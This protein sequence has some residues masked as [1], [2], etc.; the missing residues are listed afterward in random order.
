[1]RAGRG[2]GARP[3]V[4]GGRRGHPCRP[5]ESPRALEALGEARLPAAERRH[6]HAAARVRTG[7]CVVACCGAGLCRLSKLR[8]RFCTHTAHD[9]APV[10][11]DSLGGV[12]SAIVRGGGVAPALRPGRTDDIRD[13]AAV[14]GLLGRAGGSE[15]PFRAPGGCR[16]EQPRRAAADPSYAPGMADNP[17]LI[18]SCGIAS[19]QTGHPVSRRHAGRAETVLPSTSRNGARQE[20]EDNADQAGRSQGRAARQGRP[21][22]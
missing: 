7:R 4:T 15:A 18:S 6:R 11:S 14:A 20:P 1:M 19:N 8:S 9:G 12:I 2:R 3:G 17:P 16:T 10:R 13:R 22:S 21:G 5:R